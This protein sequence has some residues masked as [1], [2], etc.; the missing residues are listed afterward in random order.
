VHSNGANVSAPR[1][2]TGSLIAGLIAESCA[3]H[4]ARREFVLARLLAH[5][6]VRLC[7]NGLRR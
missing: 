5:M 7:G 3:S 2:P 1:V 6:A 4:S